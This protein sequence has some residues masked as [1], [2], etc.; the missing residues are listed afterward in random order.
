MGGVDPERER[1]R[2]SPSCFGCSKSHLLTNG[3]LS[4]PLPCAVA[5]LNEDGLFAR[6]FCLDLVDRAQRGS[7]S[8][9]HRCAWC[10]RDP[11]IQLVRQLLVLIPFRYTVILFQ[12]QCSNFAYQSPKRT[13]L[14]F[15]SG[16]GA[17]PRKCPVHHALGGEVRGPLGAKL[18][19][20]TTPAANQHGKLHQHHTQFGNALIFAFAGHDTTGCLLYTSPSPRDRG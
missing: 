16:A 20:T 9:V 10:C 17:G 7:K 11:S 2:R 5:G 15:V 6:D 14:L 3:V 1:F 8:T 13:G 19:T 18:A 12:Q 4:T